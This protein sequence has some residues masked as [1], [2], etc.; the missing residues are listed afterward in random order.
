MKPKLIFYKKKSIFSILYPIIFCCI[1]LLII[2]IFNR[3]IK[4]D[5]ILIPKFSNNYYIIPKDRGGE[6]IHHLDKKSLHLNKNSF[7]TTEITD[8]SFLNFSIQFFVS[9]DYNEIT[10]LLKKFLNMGE[11]FYKKEDFYILD[12]KT[13]IGIDYFLLYKNFNN[14]IEASNY[15]KKYLFQ[16][17][18]CL[19]VNVK[20]FNN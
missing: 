13:N 6:K 2:V 3:F 10:Q 9:S 19:I 18:N 1:V 15:C 17:K 20:N 4:N 16:I 8:F 11:K 7:E 14:K 5:F 12:F